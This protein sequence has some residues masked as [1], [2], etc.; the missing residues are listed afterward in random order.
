MPIPKTPKFLEQ[1]GKG[2]RKLLQGYPSPVISKPGVRS[3]QNGSRA[4]TYFIREVSGG[5]R[6]LT[7]K[8]LDKQVAVIT[9]IA[10]NTGDIISVDSVRKT[11]SRYGTLP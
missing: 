6:D 4:R 11:R 2:L 1:A 5:I 9:D 3:D 10:F 7:G 8:W